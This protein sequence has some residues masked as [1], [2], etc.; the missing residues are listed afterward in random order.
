MSRPHRRSSRRT[1]RLAL[2][3]AIVALLALVLAAG[4]LAAKAGSGETEE[5][6]NYAPMGSECEATEASIADTVF[7]D[8]ISGLVFY[9][10]APYDGVVT[11]WTVRI[12]YATKPIQL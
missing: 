1:P 12:G 8:E 9:T 7:Q 4:A 6:S 2:A 5:E 10:R 3:A 11:Q